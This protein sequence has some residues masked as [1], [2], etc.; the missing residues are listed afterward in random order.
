MNPIKIFVIDDHKLI[1]DGIATLIESI[2]GFKLSGKANSGISLIKSL[3]TAAELPDICLIDIEMPGINGI[4]ATKIIK[5]RFPE[6]KVLALTM[7]QESY[8]VNRMILAGADGYLLKN[9]DREVFENS[10]NKIMKDNTFFIKGIASQGNKNEKISDQVENLTNREKQIL[11][12]IANGKSNKEISKEL[13]IS[14]RTVDTHRTNLKRKLKAST[15]ADLV[16]YA[17]QN[18]YL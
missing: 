11:R 12:L 6:I 7:H 17:Y 10:V 18:G 8:F 2:S 16:Q 4:E 3:E 5:K 9:V 14:H 1:L 13:F 15:I